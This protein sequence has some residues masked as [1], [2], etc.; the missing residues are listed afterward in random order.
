MSPGSPLYD[1]AVIGGGIVGLSTAYHLQN[2]EPGASVLVIEKETRLAQHQTSH[3][4]GV[5]HAGVY[6]QPGSL[7]AEFCKRG[8][9]ATMA[10]C[11]QHHI[12][13]AQPGKLLVATNQQE[14]QRMA[15]LQQRCIENGIEVAAI[16]AAT[17][18]QLEPNITG[19]AALWVRDSG[20]VD[21]SR[22]AAEMARQLTAR[23]GTILTGCALQGV[24][25][26]GST[27]QLHTSRGSL[28]TR[29]AIGCAGLAADR[30]CDLFGI[31]REFAIIPFRGEYYQL[32][33]TK[34]DWV[35]RLIYPIPDPAMPFLGV[36][37]TPMI[38]GRLTV[39]PN[40]V[41]GWKREGYK[42]RG[43]F[44]MRDSL[45]LL[46]FGGFWK[47]I[48]RHYR[49]GCSE[50]MNS[51]IKSRYLRLVRKYSPRLGID[52]LQACPAGI[53]AQAV[54]RSGEL[55]HDFLFAES[56]LSLHVCNAPSPAATS[57]IPIGEYIA[58]RAR[59]KRQTPAS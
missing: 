33:D 20:I 36:H 7:K 12:P 29:L 40:A 25:R 3:N 27:L 18:R 52:D 43:N 57:S 41:L 10:F 23:G 46:G 56:E 22:V 26:D 45:D 30:V 58:E 6:Y 14:L 51:W 55:V 48:A 37:L 15:G 32:P 16:N 38:D 24:N 28:Q 42:T 59:R 54:T 2:A 44:S 9:R 50:L 21:Y 17:L 8:A 35:S 11:R 19:L 13:F 53:R 4:S 34:R 47:V 1:Y 31:P 5:I 49:S 39:G